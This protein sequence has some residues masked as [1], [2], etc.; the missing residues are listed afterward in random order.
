MRLVG[1]RPPW[2]SQAMNG[3]H[4]CGLGR[5]A[6]GHVVAGLLQVLTA[7]D[8]EEMCYCLKAW[9]AL[10]R[11]VQFGATPSTVEALQATAVVDRL[12]RAVGALSIAVSDRIQVRI[13]RPS[14]LHPSVYRVTLNHTRCVANSAVTAKPLQYES[15]RTWQGCSMCV[16]PVAHAMPLAAAHPFAECAERLL[17]LCGP[18]PLA[19]GVL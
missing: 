6:D 11:S 7:G 5:G 3:Q 13:T 14:P 4:A 9:Q 18:H 16:N 17:G 15:P 12:R 19:A 2:F 10:P 1:T 8:N